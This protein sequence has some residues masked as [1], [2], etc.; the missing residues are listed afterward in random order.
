MNTGIVNYHAISLL[1]KTSFC[2][3]SNI[4]YTGNFFGLTDNVIAQ[5]VQTIIPLL[6]YSIP[7]GDLKNAGT[8][9]AGTGKCQYW[10]MPVMNNSGTGQYQ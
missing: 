8:A 2:Y 10:K 1:Y 4:L 6:G 7:K 3:H 5:I 9:N